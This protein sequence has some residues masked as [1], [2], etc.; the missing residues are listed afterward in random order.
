MGFIVPPYVNALNC[1]Q[2][3][4]IFV[5]QL[6]LPALGLMFRARRL[7]QQRHPREWGRVARAC[8]PGAQAGAAHRVDVHTL[9]AW[10][11]YPPAH[12]PLRLLLLLHPAAAG[13]LVPQ[14][15]RRAVVQLHDAAGA[16]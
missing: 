11:A 6:L 16:G 9:P 1:L 8:A 7:L 10:P 2:L 13:R 4:A 14:V 12:A 15:C 5:F 3:H